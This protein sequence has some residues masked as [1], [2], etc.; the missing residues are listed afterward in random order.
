M[1]RIV[2]R[3]L[4]GVGGLFG[5]VIVGG[6]AFVGFTVHQYDSS[7]DKVYDVPVPQVTRSTDPVVL[8]RG[9]HLAESVGACLDCHGLDSGG[10]EP[11]D[12]GPMGV[13]TGP[14]ISS[15]GMGAVYSDGELFRLIRHG[16]KKDG[17]SVQFM[18]SHE[19]GWLPDDDIV[20]TISYLRTMPPVQ[21]PNGPMRVGLLAKILDRFDM[22]IIDTAR[23]IDHEKPELAPPPSPTAAYGK[24]L[25]KGCTG[26]HGANLS[27]GPIP[28]APPEFPTPLN[29]T[30]DETG[31]KGWTYADFNRLLVEGI[32]KNGKK[33]DP[34]MPIK[35]ISKL[36]EVEKKALWA[37]LAELPPRPL[38]GR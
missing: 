23:R 32:R 11:I 25:A 18:P 34:F 7:M 27:G 13:L 15:A 26:C 3:V 12:A 24:F 22:F 4:L 21:K 31:L 1:N 33:L 9:Q 19:I 38:G 2:K 28:G 8:A 5:L 30:T 14:N 35:S 6:G 37:Y 29:L 10:G 17:R 16:I 36:N 20:A